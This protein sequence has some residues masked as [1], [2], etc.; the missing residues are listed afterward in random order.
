M[1]ISLNLLEVWLRTFTSREKVI[2][3]KQ[4]WIRSVV[5]GSTS[6]P[7]TMMDQLG[8]CYVTVR[9]PRRQLAA[10][11]QQREM[12]EKREHTFDHDE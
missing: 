7:V 11:S 8:Q 12:S 1:R 2:L 9:H 10:Y 3:C 5:P 6:S 4:P